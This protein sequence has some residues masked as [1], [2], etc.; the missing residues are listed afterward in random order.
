MQPEQDIQPWT[1]E[2]VYN[3]HHIHLGELRRDK[4]RIDDPMKVDMPGV[5]EYIKEDE[6]RDD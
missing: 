6:D 3:P 1:P 4:R 2:S 5:S